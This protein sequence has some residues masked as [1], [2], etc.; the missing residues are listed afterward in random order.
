MSN[1]DFPTPPEGSEFD[2]SSLGRPP[3]SE[4]TQAM[5]SPESEPTQAMPA[6]GS[7]PPDATQVMPVVPSLPPT[8]ATALPPNPDPTAGQPPSPAPMIPVVQEPTVPWYKQ[9]GPLAGMLLGVLAVAGIIAFLVVS[10][11]G[12]DEA[13]DVDGGLIETD[14]GVVSLLVIRNDQAGSG[15][16]T[17]IGA[18]VT[19]G[20]IDAPV[21]WI[22]PTGAASGQAV[23]RLTD[24]N[25]RAEFRWAPGEGAPV[26]WTTTVALSET[27]PGPLVDD[28]T[29]ACQLERDETAAELVVNVDVTTDPALDPPQSAVYTFPNVEFVLGD[30]VTCTFTSIAAPVA[31]TSVVETSSTLPASTSSV[32]E[33]ST[34]A[35]TTTT[36][37]PATTT[38]STTTTTLPPTTTT[39]TTTTTVPPQAAPS[40]RD[41]LRSNTN[42]SESFALLDRVGLIDE[43]DRSTEPFTL[44]VPDNGAITALRNA[45]GDIDFNDDA[46][47]RDLFLVHLHVDDALTAQQ[48]AGRTEIAVSLGEPQTI[49]GAETP[50]TIGG[51]QVKQADIR[52]DGGIVHVVGAAFTR[53][54]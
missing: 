30:R 44:F 28:V 19:V 46:D 35:S 24:A 38:T 16:S 45:P 9:P 34:T 2:L 6:P 36:T 18:T 20:P 5:P 47:V 15:V 37:V 49:D 23:D 13:D 29:G 17:R 1:D 31:A 32:P 50:L 14:D 7:L 22:I 41:V 52:V 43:L 12:D 48:L 21:T 3:E 10:S 53:Q 39:T 33:T 40:L 26:D 42:A 4:P 54:N 51:A 8:T 25:G 11:G 27:L